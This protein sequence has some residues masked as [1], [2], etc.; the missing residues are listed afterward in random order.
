MSKSVAFILLSASIAISGVNC[1]N[2]WKD[3]IS[4]DIVNFIGNLP[5]PSMQN[6]L[7]TY[8]ASSTPGATINYGQP[9]VVFDQAPSRPSPSSANSQSLDA[10]SLIS[11]YQLI[12]GQNGGFAPLP[13]ISGQ[14]VASS[15]GSSQSQF[16]GRNSECC[17]GCKSPDILQQSEPVPERVRIVVVDDCNDKKENSEDSTEDDS[18]DVEVMVPRNNRKRSRTILYKV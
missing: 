8:T 4:Q 11:L 17:C 12:S 7:T 3:V 5:V 16:S 18:E 6:A 14:N 2:S 13:N 10:R 1:Q 9:V 15:Y